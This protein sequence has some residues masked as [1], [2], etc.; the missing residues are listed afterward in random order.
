[1][2][3]CASIMWRISREG[4]KDSFMMQSVAAQ[5]TLCLFFITN[6]YSHCVCAR[7]Q[8]RGRRNDSRV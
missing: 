4:I 7:R 5:M 3:E 8:V 2:S 1:M 6:S